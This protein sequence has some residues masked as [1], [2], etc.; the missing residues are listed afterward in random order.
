MDAHPAVEVLGGQIVAPQGDDADAMTSGN[1]RLP[2]AA[3]VL[4][5]SSEVGV[6]EV[7][8]QQY[9]QWVLR[10]SGVFRTER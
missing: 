2:E 5:D 3:H 6:V 1:E 10:R 7:G 4:F 9:L 8:D